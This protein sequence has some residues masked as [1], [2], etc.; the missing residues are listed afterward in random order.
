[1]EKSGQY[2]INFP[3]KKDEEGQILI[4]FDKKKKDKKIIKKKGSKSEKK[5]DDNQ[6]EIDFEAAKK[7]VEEERNREWQRQLEESRKENKEDID[8]LYSG[9]YENENETKGS[10][11]KMKIV[12]KAEVILKEMKFSIRKKLLLELNMSRKIKD[13]EETFNDY[14]KVKEEV[15]LVKSSNFDKYLS[16]MSLLGAHKSLGALERKLNL[17]TLKQISKKAQEIKGKKTHVSANIKSLP[18]FKK[19]V[20]L[21]D[22]L[23]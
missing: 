9:S 7:K 2:E 1:M 14:K 19:L 3:P 17:N 21:L 6:L 5:I 11:E 12:E 23:E 4:D 18:G 8:D 10:E 15:N 22:S 20:D 13:N 16:L